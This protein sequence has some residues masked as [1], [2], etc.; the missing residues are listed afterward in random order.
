[1]ADSAKIEN[2]D[3][4]ETKNVSSGGQVYLSEKLAGKEVT[5]AWRVNDDDHDGEQLDNQSDS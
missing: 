3:G 1:M 4:M 2:A 5:I